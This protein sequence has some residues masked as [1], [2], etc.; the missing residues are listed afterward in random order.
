MGFVHSM[1]HHA[2]GCQDGD[3]GGVLAGV[4]GVLA[5]IPADAAPCWK[6]VSHLMYN[7][8]LL[9]TTAMEAGE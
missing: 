4:V 1:M 3:S 6:R 7:E 9:R 2:A 5:Q 8:G